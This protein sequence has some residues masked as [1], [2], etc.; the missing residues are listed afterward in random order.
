LDSH[1]NLDLPFFRQH[2]FVHPHPRG[3]GYEKAG[4]PAAKDLDSRS[5][6]AP[7]FF[8]AIRHG[9][10]RGPS[11]L[12]HVFVVQVNQIAKC[13]TV[14]HRAWLGRSIAIDVAFRFERPFFAAQKVKTN[15]PLKSESEL[16]NHSSN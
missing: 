6:C 5:S 16:I 12:A 2:R 14:P 1:A 11:S 10:A 8:D 9:P 13:A 7:I 3:P 15:S 4:L